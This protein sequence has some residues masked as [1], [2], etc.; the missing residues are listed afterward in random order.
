M[1][2]NPEFAHGLL[3][4]ASALQHWPFIKT[5]IFVKVK[6]DRIDSG[7]GLND[8]Q[9]KRQY[10]AQAERTSSP[11]RTASETRRTSTALLLVMMF[12]LADLLVPSAVPN[13]PSLDE[14][15]IVYSVTTTDAPTYDSVIS[16]TSPNTVGNQSGAGDLGISEFAAESRLLFTFPMNLTSSS[17]IQSA[18]L[19]LVCTTDSVSMTQINVYTASVATW[20]DS[21][22]TWMQSDSNAHGTG[23]AQTASATEGLGS[24]L[25]AHL[26][27]GHSISM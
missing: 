19:G 10:M 23:K 14:Q 17:S 18:T 27:T 11:M 12:L 22:A 8:I 24:R 3:L 6:S 13:Q 21:E 4:T 20:N 26:Q 15:S 5:E 1:T 7:D 25:S 16:D 2:L 9:A